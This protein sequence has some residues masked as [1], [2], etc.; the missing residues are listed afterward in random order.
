MLKV[1]DKVKVIAGSDKTKE[2]TILKVLRKE[3]RVIVSGVN[4]VKK[5]KRPTGQESG[6]ILEVEAPIHISNVKK[7]ESK[8]DKKNEK[9]TKK[10]TVKTSKPKAK[11][12][13]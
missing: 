5:H 9:E 11:K 1:G 7:L 2:G 10:N 6:G 12:A 8:S 4:V 13:N 3:D